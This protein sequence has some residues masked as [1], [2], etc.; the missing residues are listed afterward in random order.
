MDRER[1]LFFPEYREELY[2]EEI[3]NTREKKGVL[4]THAFYGMRPE[5]L[6][7]DAARMA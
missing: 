2:R 7:Y 1:A 3:K 6:S 4:R 5:G